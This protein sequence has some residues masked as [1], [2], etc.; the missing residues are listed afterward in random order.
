MYDLA[1]VA[2]W[3]P[4]KTYM[5]FKYVAHDFV[6]WICTIQILHKP[7][8]AAGEELDDLTYHDLSDLSE[9]AMVEESRH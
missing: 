9:V 3:E 1:H 5:I 6:G 8:T 2:G 7:P 4:N